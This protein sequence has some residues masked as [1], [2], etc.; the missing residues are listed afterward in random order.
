VTHVYYKN[1][2]DCCCCDC[3]AEGASPTADFSYYQTDDDPCT[4]DLT[5]ESTAGTCGEIVQWRW[6]V[7]GVLVSSSQNPTGIEVEDG[8]DVTLEVTDSAGCTDSVVMEINC[9]EFSVTNCLCCPDDIPATVT[10]TM[11][12]WSTNTC[13]NSC[14]PLNGVHVLSYTATVGGQ[15]GF[16]KLLAEDGCQPTVEFQ[17]LADVCIVDE[18]AVQVNY[19]STGAIEYRKELTGPCRGTHVLDAIS[20]GAAPCNYPATVTLTI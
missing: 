20:V 13:I 14:T 2:D 11:S 8:D 15:C 9:V 7:N 16:M 3:E 5:D 1:A 18:L 12:G 19:T 17:I 10:V 4:I 6:Y